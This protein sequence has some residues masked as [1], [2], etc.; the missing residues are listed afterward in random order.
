MR[1]QFIHEGKRF[2]FITLVVKERR[3]LLSRRVKDEIVELLP[4]GER[5]KERWIASHQRDPA[6]TASN[7]VIMPDH[8]HLLLIADFKVC[9]TFDILDWIMHFM[10]ETGDWELWDRHLYFQLSFSLR[11]LKAIR[12]YIKMNPARAWW[13]ETHRDMFLRR[14][15]FRHDLLDPAYPWTAFGN[16]ALLG[17]PFLFQVRLTTKKTPVELESEIAAVV[18]KARHGMVPVSGFISPGEKEVY[19]RLLAEPRARWV[20]MLPHGLP[21]R[22]DPSVEDSRHLAE[23]R[24]L[25]LS[26]FS[27]SVP[28][29]PISRANC[30]AMNDRIAELCAKAGQLGARREQGCGG[31]QPP[32]PRRIDTRGAWECPPNPCRV[33]RTR[34][35][36][37]GPADLF[38]ARQHNSKRNDD[39]QKSDVDGP[40]CRRVDAGALI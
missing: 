30:L 23:G 27:A 8:V 14:A 36:G 5:V 6:V 28:A 39:M 40:G 29:S 15:G 10:R 17:N 7:F 35:S 9:P 26:A 31:G 11:Q 22:Y 19:R 16:L 21:P 34:G 32:N 38:N 2:F 37:R 33:Q 1:L 18:E 3:C 25:I 13:K 12:R 4:E 24:V 20:K